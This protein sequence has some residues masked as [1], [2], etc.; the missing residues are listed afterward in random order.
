MTVQ[1]RRGLPIT[2]YPLIEQTDA[3]G[4]T[5]F[6]HDE[7]NPITLRASLFPRRGAKA[8]VT[9]QQKINVVQVGV[10]DAIPGVDIGSRAEFMDKTWD[11]VT[12]PEYHLGAKRHTRHWTFDLR[13]RPSG[14]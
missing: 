11:V 8:E 5:H 3:R 10:K 13:E 1:R 4:N 7:S 12:P 9:G 6:I 2:V 14:G